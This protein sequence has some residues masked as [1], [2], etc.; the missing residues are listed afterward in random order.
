MNHVDK[1]TCPDCGSTEIYGSLPD[2]RDFAMV[3]MCEA[4]GYKDE[5]SCEY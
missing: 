5:W 4:C 2:D 3:V 1:P